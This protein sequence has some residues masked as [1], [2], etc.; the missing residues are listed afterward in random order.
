MHD[1]K[2]VNIY[3]AIHL[4]INKKKFPPVETDQMKVSLCSL[5]GSV[6]LKCSQIRC[7]SIKHDS[8]FILPTVIVTSSLQWLNVYLI[9]AV[10]EGDSKRTSVGRGVTCQCLKCRLAT[11]PSPFLLTY[12]QCRDGCPWRC[13]SEM[14]LSSSPTCN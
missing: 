7:L 14:S 9:W 4:Y 8:L 3:F 10:K 13:K 5:S 1:I 12:L 6:N 2:T 11:T